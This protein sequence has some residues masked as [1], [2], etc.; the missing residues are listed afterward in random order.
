MAT[1]D[2]TYTPPSPA[3]TDDSSASAANDNGTLAATA[4][5][6]GS[7]RIRVR[8]GQSSTPSEPYAASIAAH[9]G[10]TAPM[11]SVPVA[12]PVARSKR[13]TLLS[14]PTLAAHAESPAIVS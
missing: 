13:P 11:R 2:I 9:I 3:A 5:A 7:I 4:P 10:P 6:I 14:S 8:D 1:P 12:W